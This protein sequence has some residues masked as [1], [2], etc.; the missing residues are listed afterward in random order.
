MFGVGDYAF[1][2]W[3]VAISGFYKRLEFC[4]LG[5][6]HRKPIVLDDTAYFLPCRTRAEAVLLVALLH[7]RPAQEFLHS[8][9]FWDAKRPI[10]AS[11][12]GR[13]DLLAL[14]TQRSLDLTTHAASNPYCEHGVRS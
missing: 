11:I 4:V 10:T 3:K 5:R 14:A 12:L 1:A 7:S 13:L 8:L 6:F 9:I 2:P